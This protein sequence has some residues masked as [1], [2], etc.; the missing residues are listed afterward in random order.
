MSNALVLF[1][2]EGTIIRIQCSIEDKMKDIC[3]KFS[4]KMNKNLNSYY[5]LYGGNPLN[6]QL[7]FKELANFID[8]KEMK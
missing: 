4:N 1:Y 8:R 5:F 7:R 2:L 6:F 3:Q